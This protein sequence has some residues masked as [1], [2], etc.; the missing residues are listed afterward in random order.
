[1]V[2]GEQKMCSG[3]G[4]GLGF[5]GKMDEVLFPQW[6]RGLEHAAIM[7]IYSEISSQYLD[8]V[9]TIPLR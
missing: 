6:R 4:T 9:P 2:A 5:Q 8:G 1:M 7:I 3:A